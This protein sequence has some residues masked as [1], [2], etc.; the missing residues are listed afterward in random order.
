ME[1]IA[2]LRGPLAGGTN[3]TLTGRHLN[4]GASLQVELQET[5]VKHQAAPSSMGK[6]VSATVHR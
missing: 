5:W 4:V 3:V 6:S 1:S 2:P